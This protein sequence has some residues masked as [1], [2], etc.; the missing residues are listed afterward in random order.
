MDKGDTQKD[1]LYLGD[2]KFSSRL[3][4]GSGKQG[5]HH[6][7]S[8]IKEGACE[9]MTVAIRRVNLDYKEENILNF[10]NDDVMILPNTSGARNSDEAVRIARLGRELCGHNFVKLEISKDHKYFLPDNYETLKAADLLTKEGFFVMAYM[11]PDLSF[12]LSMEEV[13]VGAVMP[14][15]SP[16]GSNNGLLNMGILSIMIEEVSVPIIVDAGIGRPSEANY[17]MELGVDAV[18]LNTAIATSKNPPLMAKAFKE[19]VESGRNAYLAGLGRVK[20]SGEASSPLTGFLE[21]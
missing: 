14:L 10:I 17:L 3:I 2:R 9:M 8:I 18:M 20:K 13:G 19:A 16:I 4:L 12:A 5:N 6:L 7:P 11:N 15:A 1:Y 21:R